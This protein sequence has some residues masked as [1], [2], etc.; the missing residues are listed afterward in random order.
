[1]TNR[2]IFLSN[3]RDVL[4]S[5]SNVFVELVKISGLNPA[6]DFEHSNLRR[7]DFGTDDIREY[8]FIGADLRGADLSRALYDPSSFRNAI[9]DANTKFAQSLPPVDV[10]TVDAV[11][12]RHA[13]QQRTR[14]AFHEELIQTARDIQGEIDS[15]FSSRK[16]NVATENLTAAMRYAVSGGKRLRAHLVKETAG[17]FDFSGQE[18]TAVGMA[19]EFFHAYS[20][21]HDD[22]PCMDD[23]DLRRGVPTVHIRWDESTA[24]LAG[25]A[26]HSAGYEILTDPA[27]SIEPIKRIEIIRTLSNALGSNGMV[28]GQAMDIAAETSTKPLTIYEI[29][30]LQH[31]KTGAFLE[32]SCVVGAIL[33]SAT[34]ADLDR[35]SQYGRL[36]GLAFQIADDILDCEA[37]NKDNGKEVQGDYYSVGKATFVSL[38]GYEGAKNRVSE[39]VDEAVDSIMPFGDLSLGLQQMARFIQ[40]R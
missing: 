11:T 37:I 19:V 4:K 12:M 17:M 26:L 33:G 39:L 5:K 2:S 3:A 21:V 18:V 30:E 36:L 10:R 7:V 1:M 8:S 25:D 29:V 34:K 24:I 20:L 15:F 40:T 9:V 22:L 35:V 31:A 14:G 6:S 38:L 16:P 23:D 13:R 27:L 28:G 32:A